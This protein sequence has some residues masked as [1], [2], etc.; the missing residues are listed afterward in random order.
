[1]LQKLK[2]PGGPMSGLEQVGAIRLK[3]LQVFTEVSR[4]KSIREAGRRLNLTSGQVSKAVQLLEARVGIRLFQRSTSGV[5][6]SDA[7]AELLR[8]CEEILAS[9]QKMEL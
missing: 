7:G 4:A 6:L 9:G 3:D 8:V 5:L 2:H 1:M